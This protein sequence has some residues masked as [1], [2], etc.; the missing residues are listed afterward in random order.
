M[1]SDRSMAPSI[2]VRQVVPAPPERVFE[3]WTDPAQ[4]RRWWGP[5]GVECIEAVVDLRVGGAFRLANQLPNGHVLEISGEYHAIDPPN[6]LRH[7]WHVGDPAEGEPSHVTVA[8]TPH[9]QGTEV[10]V[11]HENVTDPAD[12]QSREAGW[13]GC[14]DGVTAYLQGS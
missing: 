2:V 13:I 14:L 6:L 11:T 8:F 4:L 9:G 10:T 7:S 12:R 3:A 5:P 1:T